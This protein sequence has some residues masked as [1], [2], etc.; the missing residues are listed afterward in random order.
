MGKISSVKQSYLFSRAYKYGKC[1]ATAHVVVYALK[2]KKAS[3]NATTGLGLTVA[4]KYGNAVKR[5]RAR[6]IMREAYRQ[7]SDR[8]SGGYVIIA[9]A[10]HA[11]ATAKTQDVYADMVYAF[12]KLGILKA[13][14]TK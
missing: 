12:K 13:E 9:V 3:E 5:S 2:K 6:R 4:K 8:L 11:L 7:L 1:V 14:E 10:R